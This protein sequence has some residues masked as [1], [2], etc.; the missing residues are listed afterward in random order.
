MAAIPTEP[1]SAR[2][3]RRGPT[4]GAA[5]RTRVALWAV[6]LLALAGLGGCAAVYAEHQ[7]AARQ[8]G[9]ERV[10]YDNRVLFLLHMNEDLRSKVASRDAKIVRISTTEADLARLHADVAAAR[11]ALAELAAARENTRAAVRA[12][13][14][15][16][17]AEH[18]KSMAAAR[19]E[20]ARA[21][22]ERVKSLSIVRAALARGAAVKREIGESERLLARLDTE[23]GA[24]RG[25]SERLAED[26]AD[27]RRKLAAIEARTEAARADLSAAAAAREQVALQRKSVEAKID[28]AKT[29]LATVNATLQVRQIR[30]EGLETL[31]LRARSELDRALEHL[32]EVRRRIGEQGGPLLGPTP[33]GGKIGPKS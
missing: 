30:A 16:A 21:E 20:L 6:T 4:R 27:A 19:A 32:R 12:E 10:A 15:E 31:L 3:A 1:R 23:I 17:E 26:V 28:A 25:A 9:K 22:A 7:S 13:L 5:G 11:V 2:P 18:E 24:R 29:S 14:A 8:W 33:G